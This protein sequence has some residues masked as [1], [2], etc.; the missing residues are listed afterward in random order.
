MNAS[1]MKVTFFVQSASGSRSKAS[2]YLSL[3]K[4]AR[5]I[6][7]ETKEEV[8]VIVRVEE[9]DYDRTYK[10]IDADGTERVLSME[11]R[12]FNLNRKQMIGTALDM[13]G[14]IWSEVGTSTDN[15]EELDPDWIQSELLK[16][17]DILEKL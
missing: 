17:R 14:S 5:V 1:S 12:L 2:E 16:V 3:M 10:L 4:D 6:H 8:I 7:E 15:D 11:A 13:L 9:A